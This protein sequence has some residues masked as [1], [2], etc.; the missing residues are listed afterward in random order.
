M[1]WCRGPRQGPPP[2]EGAS[3]GYPPVAQDRLRLTE[4][5]RVVPE[6]KAKWADDLKPDHTAI[7][8]FEPTGEPD[9]PYEHYKDNL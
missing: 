3:V 2:A 8:W 1:S 9:A 6:L 5:G 4:D 7:E